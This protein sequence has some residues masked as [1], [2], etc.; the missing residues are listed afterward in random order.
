MAIQI[1]RRT[2]MIS[3]TLF[4]IIMLTLAF[5]ASKGV[6]SIWGD[7]VVVHDTIL[8]PDYFCFVETDFKRCD[9]EN[10]DLGSQVVYLD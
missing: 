3:K 8:K 9:P 10:I 4:I 7:P 5:L 1:G 2:K 6:T